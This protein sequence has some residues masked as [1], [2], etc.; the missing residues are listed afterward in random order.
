MAHYFIPKTYLFEQSEPS[1]KWTIQHSCGYPNV[2]IFIEQ[3][4]AIN[5]IIPLD[6]KYV[7]DTLCEVYFT[8]PFAGTAK[9][10]G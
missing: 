9:L 4:G 6:V 5:K 2:D 3:N 10:V 8:V 1:S 7:S